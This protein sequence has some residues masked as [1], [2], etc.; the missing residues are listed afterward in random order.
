[1]PFGLQNA[2]QTFQRFMDKVFRGLSF[3]FTYMY[4]Y[5]D[6]ALITTCSSSPEEHLQHLQTVF[7]CLAKYGIVI[8]P[9]KCL[10][11][12]TELD[13]L[14][15]HVSSQGIT[16]LPDKVKAVQDFPLPNSQR[17]LRQFISLVIFYHRFLPHCAELML[18]LHALLCSDKRKSQTIT[19]NDTALAAF[20]TPKDALATATLLSYPQLDSPTCSQILLLAWQRMHPMLVLEQ[21]YSS[22]SKAKGTQF[23]FSPRN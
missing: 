4:M 18:P 15:H 6:D 2:A 13:F 3:T 23:P 14:G 16:F 5:I 17:K 8:N 22:M 20:Y 12:V 21:S 9:N 11:G 1:M 7:D 10:F 19:W